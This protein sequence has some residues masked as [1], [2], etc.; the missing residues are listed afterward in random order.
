[1]GNEAGST[2]GCYADNSE[3]ELAKGI[4]RKQRQSNITSQRRDSKKSVNKPIDIQVTSRSESEHE[5]APMADGF[6]GQQKII[7]VLE[8]ITSTMKVIDDDDKNQVTVII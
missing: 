3:P 5:L 7:E 2:A 8:D 1:M 4:V 6:V